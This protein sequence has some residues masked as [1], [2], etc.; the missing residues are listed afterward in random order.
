MKIT[1]ITFIIIFILT[2]VVSI[3]IY[4][5]AKKDV[6]VVAT[7]AT[8]RIV[9]RLVY[10]FESRFRTVEVLGEEIVIHNGELIK[11]NIDS[12]S[13]ILY[14]EST[15]CLQL[16]PDGVVSYV[17]PNAVE[18]DF[19]GID[20]LAVE[21]SSTDAIKSIETRENGVSGPYTLTNGTKGVV[22]RS[23]I[24]VEDEFWGFSVVILDA[25][26]LFMETGISDLDQLGYEYRIFSN[27]QG[28]QIVAA[29]SVGFDENLNEKIMLDVDGTEWK[30]E[31][32]RADYYWEISS[33]T[34]IWAIFITMSNLLTCTIIYMLEKSR[35]GLKTEAITDKL[36][37]A[38]NRNGLSSFIPK[39][40]KGFGII[41]IDLNKFKPVN[42]TYGHD[43]GDKLLIAY[44]KRLKASLKENTTISRVGGDE[45]LLLLPE[46][47]NKEDMQ[48]VIERIRNLSED[49]FLLE[50]KE[51]NIS[52]SIGYSTSD[53][54]DDFTKLTEIADKRMFEDKK[55]RKAGR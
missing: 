55:T 38:Y 19:I 44:V 1:R 34:A 45:F 48:K 5:N 37:G 22:V 47:T 18:T 23:P 6:D 20:I 53:E 36:T 27:Y 16:A 35:T 14:T 52:A 46:L 54:S 24:F 40:N 29:E 31:M 9:E 39:G 3:T 28:E 10:F 12:L 26:K 49:T 33:N 15:L 21:R 4:H 32:H 11:E 13:E 17:Y 7:A 30:V 8:E 41:Y 51:I 43:M 25:D 2:I 42:D 50:E